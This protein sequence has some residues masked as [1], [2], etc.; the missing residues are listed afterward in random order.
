MT[1]RA[2]AMQHDM[3]AWMEATAASL[4]SEYEARLQAALS[5]TASGAASDGAQAELA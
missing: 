5:G 2:A 4:H 1:A 3:A